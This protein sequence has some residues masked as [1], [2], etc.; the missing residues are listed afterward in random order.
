MSQYYVG[1]DLGT[2]SCYVTV[3]EDLDGK[4]DLH[5]ESLPLPQYSLDGNVQHDTILHS[6]YYRTESEDE[7]VREI[8]GK[9]A[10]EMPGSEEDGKITLSK[11]F[12][13]TNKEYHFKDGAVFKPSDI[14]AELIKQMLIAIND[15]TRNKELKSLTITIPASFTQPMKEDTLKAALKAGLKESQVHFEYEPVAALRAMLYELEKEGPQNRFV[16]QEILNGKNA[17]IKVLVF[18]IGG[19]TLDITIYEVKESLSVDQQYRLESSQLQLSP[20]T[21]LGGFKFDEYLV[22]YL[23]SRF[24]DEYQS[25][26]EG[27]LNKEDVVAKLQDKWRGACEEVK[28]SLSNQ[29]SREPNK[30]WDQISINKRLTIPS[31]IRPATNITN[32]VQEISLNDLQKAYAPLLNHQRNPIFNAF[33]GMTFDEATSIF[34]PIYLCLQKAGISQNE[35]DVVVPVGGMSHL[36]FIGLSLQN[37][38]GAE[39]I[40]SSNTFHTDPSKCISKGAAIYEYQ[41]QEKRDLSKKLLPHIQFANRQQNHLQWEDL[42]PAKTHVSLGDTFKKILYKKYPARQSVIHIPVKWE[43]KA[44]GAIKLQWPQNINVPIY[45]L[46]ITLTIQVDIATMMINGKIDANGHKLEFSID[47]ETKLDDFQEEQ[48]KTAAVASMADIDKAFKSTMQNIKNKLIPQTRHSA[49]ENIYE[50]NGL[51]NEFKYIM[52]S[53]SAGGLIDYYKDRAFVA[54]VKEMKEIIKHC[55]SPSGLLDF[56][57]DQEKADVTLVSNQLQNLINE[58]I[59][60]HLS[61]HHGQCWSIVISLLG[62]LKGLL[63]LDLYDKLVNEGLSSHQAVIRVESARA[64]GRVGLRGN[65]HFKKLLQHIDQIELNQAGILEGLLWGVGRSMISSPQIL[66]IYKPGELDSKLEA[67]YKKVRPFL[68]NVSIASNFFSMISLFI[69]IKGPQ[70]FVGSI[71]K[72][73]LRQALTSHIQ[74]IKDAHNANE[75]ALKPYQILMQLL[76]GNPI[77]ASDISY[78]TLLIDYSK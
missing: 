22:Q 42:I 31:A 50:L 15:H 56:L 7:G 6:V 14:A 69:L 73:T 65:V 59:A 5:F 19:G 44:K 54:K 2:T 11:N 23:I 43:G 29:Y 75:T 34:D 47:D 66:D 12:M 26:Y 68:K 53:V 49:L 16:R 63:K 74:Y 27:K 28:R 55:T 67:T 64:L 39:K 52:Q 72:N 24:Y 71:L 18:D 10:Y 9:Y 33:T 76:G 48:P 40:V 37:L 70:F 13:G 8:V 25:Y 51:L 57:T 1:I 4:G 78:I 32:W 3:A 38:F 36:P 17:K 20:H 61:S 62:E 35:I 77:T 21:R 45:D 46:P 41:K 58:K 30:P 60:F